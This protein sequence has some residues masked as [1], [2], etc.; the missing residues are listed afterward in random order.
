[1]KPFVVLVAIVMLGIGV[2]GQNLDEDCPKD[3][4]FKLN[5]PNP[6]EPLDGTITTDATIQIRWSGC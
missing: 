4:E 2:F 3:G 6:I 5:P 1:M